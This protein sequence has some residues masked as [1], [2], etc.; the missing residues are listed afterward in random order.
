MISCSSS[1]RGSSD[2]ISRRLLSSLDG[3]GASGSSGSE[4]S[5]D[6]VIAT[7]AAVNPA[8]A[9]IVSRLR[10]VCFWLSDGDSGS[11]SPKISSRGSEGGWGLVSVGWVSKESKKSSSSSSDGDGEVSGWRSPFSW[12]V[13]STVSATGGTSTSHSTSATSSK[14]EELFSVS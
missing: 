10:S 5:A 13:S 12:I 2:S 14:E 1:S 7:A 8:A 4:A 6:E 3:S 11:F 9:A